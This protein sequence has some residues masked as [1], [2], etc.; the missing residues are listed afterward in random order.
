MACIAEETYRSHLDLRWRQCR[1]ALDTRFMT[2]SEP[3]FDLGLVAA[4]NGELSPPEIMAA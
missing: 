1:H 4:F 3:D 2:L